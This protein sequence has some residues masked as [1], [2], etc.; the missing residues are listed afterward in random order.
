MARCTSLRPALRGRTLF[1]FFF[2]RRS[3]LA[4]GE[5]SSDSAENRQD[6]SRPTVVRLAEFGAFGARVPGQNEGAN[7]KHHKR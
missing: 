7:A 5:R 1:F 4:D 3:G 2:R 6:V